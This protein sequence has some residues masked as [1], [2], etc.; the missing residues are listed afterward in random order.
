[1]MSSDPKGNHSKYPKGAYIYDVHMVGGGEGVNNID[2]KLRMVD[3]GGWRGE[4]VEG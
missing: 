2:P 3:D 1:M 4:W